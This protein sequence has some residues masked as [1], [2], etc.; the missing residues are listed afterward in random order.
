MVDSP[1]AWPEI[2]TVAMVATPVLVLVLVLVAVGTRN[3]LVAVHRQ[4]LEEL[5]RLRRELSRAGQG[6]P[7]AEAMS[8]IGVT[9]PVFQIGDRVA[10]IDGPHLGDNGTVVPAPEWVRHGFVCVELLRERGKRYM[11]VAKLVRLDEPAG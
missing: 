6:Q 4:Q 2:A 5:T 9:E 7:A 10:V 1:F 11:P 8:R 3:R